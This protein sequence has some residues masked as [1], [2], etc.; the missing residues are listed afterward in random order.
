MVVTEKQLN[1]IIAESI[2]DAMNGDDTSRDFM[3]K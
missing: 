3:V 2:N 1:R